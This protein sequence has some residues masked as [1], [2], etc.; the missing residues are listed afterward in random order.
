[1]VVWA[2]MKHGW[3][4]SIR[5]FP[6]VDSPA[7]ALYSFSYVGKADKSLQNF[8]QFKKFFIVLVIIEPTFNRDSIVGLHRKVFWQVVHDYRFSQIFANLAQIF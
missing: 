6:L 5:L 7:Y 2:I 1:M 3:T 4:Q 8:A